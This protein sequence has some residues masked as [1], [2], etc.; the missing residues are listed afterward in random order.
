MNRVLGFILLASSFLLISSQ[1]VNEIKVKGYLIEIRESTEMESGIVTSV[2][3]NFFVPDSV[4]LSEL[5]MVINSNLDTI[6]S[7]AVLVKK[8]NKFTV[9]R[10]C[11][12]DSNQVSFRINEVLNESRYLIK[13]RV[14]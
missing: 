13:V 12:L 3:Y 10:E 8:T 7:P 2:Y 11:F 4:P 9:R 6:V 14:L 5:Y 1:T